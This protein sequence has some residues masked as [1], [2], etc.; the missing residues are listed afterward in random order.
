[1][2]QVWIVRDVAKTRKRF[3]SGITAEESNQET[4]TQEWSEWDERH[5]RL[6]CE[7]TSE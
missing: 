7:G 4:R 2:M 1:V 6:S 5:R 3:L